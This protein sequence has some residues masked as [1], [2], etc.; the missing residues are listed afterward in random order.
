MLH[1]RSSG[2]IFPPAARLPLTLRSSLGAPMEG[3]LPF[4]ACGLIIERGGGFVKSG[5]SKEFLPAI[6][7]SPPEKEG[8]PLMIL[9]DRFETAPGHA[10]G[11]T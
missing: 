5:K 4:L 10:G 6:D 7:I 8:L 3:T 11:R 9:S 1:P 2:A